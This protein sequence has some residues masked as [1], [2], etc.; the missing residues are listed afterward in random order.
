MFLAK[1]FRKIAL[2]SPPL[3]SKN[4][5]FEKCPNF[6]KNTFLGFLID[7]KHDFDGFGG[8]KPIISWRILSKID[9]LGCFLTFQVPKAGQGSDFAKKF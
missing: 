6:V 1:K 4:R 8:S 7:K 5:S 3:R 9:F 2:V